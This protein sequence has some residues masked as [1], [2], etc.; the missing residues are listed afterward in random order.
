VV[1]VPVA[2]LGGKALLSLSRRSHVLLWSSLVCIEVGTLEIP[3]DVFFLTSNELG[4]AVRALVGNWGIPIPSFWS[5]QGNQPVPDL[6]QKAA[7]RRELREARKRLTPPVLIPPLPEDHTYP[8]TDNFSEK[9]SDAMR[10]SPVSPGKVTAEASLILSPADFEKMVP[11]TILVCPATTP[12]WTPLFAQAK[13][14][15][16]DIGGI[17]AHGAIVAREY[18]IPAVLGTRDATKRI[19]SGQQITVDGD[20]G[21]VTLGDSSN[22]TETS[23]SGT[24]R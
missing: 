5:L 4:K 1:E 6:L 21:T 12:A 23:T 22:S 9:D 13:G 14:L 17:L 7:E 24:Y 18:G 10:G 11:G 19:V 15:V 16:T 8:I 3:D 20:K 2:A